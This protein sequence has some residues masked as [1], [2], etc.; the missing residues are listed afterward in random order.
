M[1]NIVMTISP[2]KR[3]LP[4]QTTGVIQTPQALSAWISD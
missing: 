4:P 3:G 1:F 2:N